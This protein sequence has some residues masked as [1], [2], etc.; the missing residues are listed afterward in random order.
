MDAVNLVAR[1]GCEIDNT[2]SMDARHIGDHD[3]DALRASRSTGSVKIGTLTALST[4]RV[5]RHDRPVRQRNPF[6]QLRL[7][8]RRH[9]LR[10]AWQSH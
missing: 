3:K 7:L 9:L 6:R 8:W 5:Y 4:L 2:S 1:P 10:T